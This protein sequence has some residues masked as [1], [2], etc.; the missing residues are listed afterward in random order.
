MVSFRYFFHR[1]TFSIVCIFFA[2]GSLACSV[3]QLTDQ[4]STVL[5]NS[6]LVE[7]LAR[8]RSPV[9]L[10]EVEFYTSLSFGKQFCLVER[11]QHSN[12]CEMEVSTLMLSSLIFKLP[13][14]REKNYTVLFWRDLNWALNGMNIKYDFPLKLMISTVIALSGT[15]SGA[16]MCLIVHF[17]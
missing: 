5:F 13:K 17:L 1:I 16:D 7:I 8:Q 2:H 10:T 14:N 3:S 15:I 12:G 11:Y 6:F 4:F 9:P